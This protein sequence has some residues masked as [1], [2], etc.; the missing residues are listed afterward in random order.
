M[1]YSMGQQ[2]DIVELAEQYGFLI[3]ED[4]P[5]RRI[6]FDGVSVPPIK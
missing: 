3:V 6:R 1:P 2:S 4:D 5:Y